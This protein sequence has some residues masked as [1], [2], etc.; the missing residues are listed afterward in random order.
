MAVHFLSNNYGVIIKQ[1]DALPGI[2]K[3]F[4]PDAQLTLPIHDDDDN[5]AT[6]YLII[7]TELSVKEEFALL[8]RLFQED[9][10]YGLTK[11]KAVRKLLH[12]GT[13]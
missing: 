6:L 1:I 4:F 2:V 3:K 10:F 11:E 7:H 9:G 12:V 5:G 8:K 13:A